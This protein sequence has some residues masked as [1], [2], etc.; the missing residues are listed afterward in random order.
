M[1]A[2]PGDRGADS[3]AGTRD[4]PADCGPLLRARDQQRADFEA[5]IATLR[6][7]VLAN[8][9]AIAQLKARLLHFGRSGPGLSPKQ[10]TDWPV[11]DEQPRFRI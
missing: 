11:S 1:Q 6:Q 5:K 8:N 9:R 10:P 4:S 7:T 2:W 3:P